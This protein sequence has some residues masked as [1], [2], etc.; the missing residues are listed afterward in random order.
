MQGRSNLLIRENNCK[1]CNKIYTSNSNNSKY[2]SNK[3]AYKV[4]YIK[5]FPNTKKIINKKFNCLFCKTEF[6][7]K[8]SNQ[9]KY[10]SKSC[11]G[12]DYRK[13]PIY[14]KWYKEHIKSESFKNNQKKYRSS[15]KGK[16][17]QKNWVKNNREHLLYWYKNWR[18]TEKGKR[19]KNYDC[20][21]RYAKKKQRTP[22][23][24]TKQDLFKIKQFY[25]KRPQG[26]EVDHIIPLCGDN[27]SG[28]HVL[29]NLQYLKAEE[30]RKKNKKY[31]VV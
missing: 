19:L 29:N 4:Y 15:T 10:C 26:Y 28:L 11:K 24:L 30:N 14:K 20:A 3:C 7:N 16:I 8:S 13:K 27:V 21:I 9:K 12:K 18:K 17:T 2:C 23:W 25:L 31:I 1:N 22:K 5:R 6:I